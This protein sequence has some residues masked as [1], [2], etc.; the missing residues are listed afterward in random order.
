MRWLYNVP[1]LQSLCFIAK[2]GCL[3]GSRLGDFGVAM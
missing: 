3:N 1:T 2:V